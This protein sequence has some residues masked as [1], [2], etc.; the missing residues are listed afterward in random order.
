M[1]ALDVFETEPLPQDS[2]LWA[3]DNVLISP[4]CSSVFE[5]WEL[6]TI[7]QFSANLARWCKGDPLSNIVD[8]QRGY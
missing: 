2:P 5:G 1:P 3:F 7:A 8:P 6:A 4:H